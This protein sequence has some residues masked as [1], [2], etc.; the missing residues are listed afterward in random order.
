LAV[1]DLH[2]EGDVRE[3]GVGTSILMASALSRAANAF[4][5]R[6]DD[7]FTVV[8]RPL[9]IETFEYIRVTRPGLWLSPPEVR[10]F[11]EAA[12]CKRALV[13]TIRRDASLFYVTLHLV[14]DEGTV[15]KTTRFM[16]PIRLLPLLPQAVTAK[17]AKML[18]IDVNPPP[19]IRRSTLVAL[20]RSWQAAQTHDLDLAVNEFEKA[21]HPKSDTLKYSFEAGD[22]SAYIRKVGEGASARVRVLLAVDPAA[23]LREA[24]KLAKD[25]TNSV[26]ARFM[27]ARSLIEMGQVKEALDV[28]EPRPGD[29]DAAEAHLLRG[30]ALMD[31]DPQRARDELKKAYD[32]NGDSVEAR[33]MYGLQLARSHDPKAAPELLSLTAWLTQHGDPRAIDALLRAFGTAPKEVSLDA[34]D[35]EELRPEDLVELKRVLGDSAKKNSDPRLAYPVAVLAAGNGDLVSAMA[36]LREA[37]RRTPGDFALNQLEGRIASEQRDHSTAFDCFYAAYKARPSA[38]TAFDAAR[39]A[40]LIGRQDQALGLYGKLSGDPVL[41]SLLPRE[42]G[43]MALETHDMN[44]AAEQLRKALE[45]QNDDV[46]LALNCER[47]FVMSGKGK[48]AATV[49]QLALELDPDVS[50]SKADLLPGVVRFD[51][52]PTTAPTSAGPGPTTHDRHPAAGLP[53][54]GSVISKIPR[55]IIMGAAGVLLL[56][57]LV[58]GVVLARRRKQERGPAKESAPARKPQVLSVAVPG[59]ATE[60]SPV[61]QRKDPPPSPLPGLASILVEVVDFAPIQIMGTQLQMDEKQPIVGAVV[62]VGNDEKGAVKTDTAAGGALLY[63]PPGEHTL[64]VR[65]GSKTL[66]KPLSVPSPE[67]MS[68]LVDI[69]E[70]SLTTRPVAP[71]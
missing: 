62:W 24:G 42:L 23:A 65:A 40:R 13:G 22:L 56:A 50:L 6:P 61:V 39:E 44:E 18:A 53:T 5:S 37:R 14:D 9:L 32:L 38:L 49:S 21:A 66:E 48:E 29:L 71:R 12:P 67:A 70:G 45:L 33:L 60:G 19:A 69:P 59:D 30:R 28:L 11:C 31:R 26:G 20:A 16:H 8:T 10:A 35:V 54:G 3:I 25:N 47:A 52:L 7:A 4:V 51:D 43:E 68:L 46:E 58:G 36:T 55:Q 57:A 15:V 34:V 41:H 1:V 17:A 63:L 2:G 27:W 64:H